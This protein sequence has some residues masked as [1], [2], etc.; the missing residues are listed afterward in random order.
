M[1]KKLALTTGILMCALL[2]SAQSKK[3]N[4][5]LG[6]Q[7]NPLFNQIL[8]L[9]NNQIV[10]NP[11]L[12]RY[13]LRDNSWNKQASIG[14]GYSV[15]T[16]KDEN[17]FET[18]TNDLSSRVGVAHVIDLNHGMEI[19]LGLD[20]IFNNR[21]VQTFNIQSFNF[22]NNIDSTITTSTTTGLGYGAGPRLNFSYSITPNF[23]IGTEATYYFL[24]LSEK[25][26]VEMKNYR[27]NGF[28]QVVTSTS[29]TNSENTG[30]EF[31][32][33]VP[34]ALFMTFRF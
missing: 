29:S 31:N 27:T 19:A 21:N 24:F 33:A 22:G 13:A 2:T 15:N 5:Y 8:N 32:L 28:G 9:G 17:G 4:H 25:T 23:S 12:L 34:I 10:D 16:T 3:Y 26:N 11:Y 7:A 18:I 1:L 20:L 6:V 30:R 14:L